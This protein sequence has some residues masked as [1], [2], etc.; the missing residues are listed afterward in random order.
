MSDI[1][2]IGLICYHIIVEGF[3]NSLCSSQTEPSGKENCEYQS[4]NAETPESSGETPESS[5]E[6]PG[7]IVKPESS[8]TVWYI[9]GGVVVGVGIIILVIYLMKKKEVKSLPS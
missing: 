7:A 1:R 8:N 3:S 5:G 4:P 2:G 6:T 9:V